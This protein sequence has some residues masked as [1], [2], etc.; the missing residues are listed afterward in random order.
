MV[1]REQVKLSNLDYR[2]QVLAPGWR[3]AVH[4]LHYVLQP[5]SPCMEN[6]HS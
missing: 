1:Y 4:V 5:Q 3:W 2:E 6:Q